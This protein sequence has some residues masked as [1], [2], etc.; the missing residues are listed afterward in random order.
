MSIVLGFAII[1][2]PLVF[3]IVP[4]FVFDKLNN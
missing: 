1:M 4:L 3:G 2:T